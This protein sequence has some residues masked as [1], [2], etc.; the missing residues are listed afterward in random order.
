MKYAVALIFFL[1]IY[2]L[3]LAQEG[4]TEKQFLSHEKYLSS[5]KLEGRFPGT[6][7]NN[8]AARYIAK[9]F[10]RLHLKQWNHGYQMPFSLFVKPQ[11][12][13]VSK[14]TVHTQNIL[15]YLE[16]KD[17]DLKNE[18]VIIGAHYDH[19]GWGGKGTGSKKKDT[20][21]IHNGADDNASGV[22]AL[23][24]IAAEIARQQQGIKRSII[25]IA[26]SG[27]EEG[28]K[29]S[30]YFM[31]HLPVPRE[32]IKLMIN[33]DMVGR[34]NTERQIYMGG[35]GTFP[36][37]E[38]LMKKLAEGSG[39][40]PVVHAGSVGGSDHVTFYKNKISVLGLHTGGHPQYHT[41]ED[42][43]SLINSKGAVEVAQYICKA[44]LAIA[45]YA[46]PIFFIPQD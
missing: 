35:A 19:L 31:H 26:F 41:P 2:K 43:L 14:D 25:F 36:G 15:G 4:V 39:L 27:E 32:A 37:G 17:G 13:S 22:S 33:M 29:G 10:K 23:L 5:D 46:Q 30:D 6:K 28:L 1:S 11:T 18:Y 16:G 7:G 34:L 12:N 8:K 42:D 21:A 3:L 9:Q 20:L 24:C 45:N 44:L 40:N 38:A